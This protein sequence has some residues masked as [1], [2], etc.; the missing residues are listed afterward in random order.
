MQSRLDANFGRAAGRI[1]GSHHLVC[2]LFLVVSFS[3]ISAGAVGTFDDLQPLPPGQGLAVPNG[4]LGLNW[5]QVGYLDPTTRNPT[6]GYLPAMVSSPHV[7]FNMFEN[8]TVISSMTSNTYFTFNGAYFGAAWN[9]GLQVNLTGWRQG[10]QKQSRTIVVNTTGSNWYDFNYVGI[11]ELRISSSGGIP[12][13][14]PDYGSFTHFVM[15]NFTVN[16]PVPEPTNLAIV[17]AGAFGGLSLT[18]RRRL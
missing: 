16:E 15:D 5:V 2:A 7:A 14:S 17:C 10:V 8:P 9:N 13:F 4:Y 3:G 11:D 12:A 18:Y 1:S 6:V